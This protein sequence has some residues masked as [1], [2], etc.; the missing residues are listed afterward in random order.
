MD[1]FPMHEQSARLALGNGIMFLGYS[2][3]PMQDKFSHTPS[4]SI[5]KTRAGIGYWS[6][7]GIDNVDTV[8]AHKDVVFGSV[9]KHTTDTLQEIYFNYKILFDKL[10]PMYPINFQ[11]DIYVF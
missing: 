1:N 10:K 8:T 3:H 5:W 6:H 9:M 4:V 11:T 7:L 2:L